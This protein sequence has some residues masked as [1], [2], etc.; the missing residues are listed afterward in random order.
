MSNYRL[1]WGIIPLIFLF[2]CSSSGSLSRYDYSYLYQE[3]Q[4]LIKPKFKVF[5]QDAD[6]SLLYFQIES[7]D[8]LYGKLGQDS[9][10]KARILCKYKLYGKKGERDILDSATTP[11]ISTGENQSNSILQGYVKVKA[12]AGELYPLEIRFRDVYRDLNVVYYHWIDK[13]DNGNDQYYLMSQGEQVLVEPHLKKGKAYNLKK[14]QLVEANEFDKSMSAMEYEMTP[15]PFA[16][17]IGELK[18]PEIDN[19]SPIRFE[20]QEVYIDSIQDINLIT[21]AEDTSLRPFFFYHFS[22][23]YPEVIEYE[24]MVGPIRYISTSAEYKKLQQAVN[25]KKELDL[26]WLKI[27]KDA[28]RTKQIIREYYR[29]VELANQY[30]TD[31]REGWKTDRGILLIV[32]GEPNN[33]YK[34][35]NREVWTYGEENQ[36]L[37]IRFEFRLIDN[38]LSRNDFR[39]VRKEEYKNNWYRAVDNWRQ[40]KIF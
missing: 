13:R 7:N 37:S 24:E 14:S 26:F 8:I 32:Y 21:T 4:R 31:Y 1:L 36:I 33:I 9:I 2:A 6:T 29:R 22:N 10:S 15:P 34:D 28:S 39:L 38:P 25:L 30:F 35:L 12:K 40:G 18:Y 11:M 16:T 19:L 3:E 17:K 27:G 20:G 5:H 23:H